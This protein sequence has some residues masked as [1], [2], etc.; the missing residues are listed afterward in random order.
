[1]DLTTPTFGL[2]KQMVYVTGLPRAGS[3]LLCQLL[4]VHSQIYSIV[5]SSPLA[6]L[7]EQLRHG[8]SD[9]PFQLAQLDVDFDLAYGRIVNAF[10]GFINGWVQETDLPV[11][12]DKNRSWLGMVQTVQQLDP[13]F[14]MLVCV[15]DPIQILG[16]IEAQHQKTLLLDFPDHMAPNSAWFRGDALFSN[17]GV[18]GGPLR[19]IENF[20]DI[21]DSCGIKERV[22][23][24][25]FERL[26][27][28]PVEEMSRIFKWLGMPDCYIDPCNLPVKPHESDSYYRYKYRHETRSKIILPSHHRISPRI[29]R[30]VF[31][32]YRWFYD[33]LYPEAYP[34]LRNGNGVGAGYGM[35]TPAGEPSP[36]VATP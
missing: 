5:H 14:R 3:T 24:V 31:Y 16:S 9:S 29:Q 7:L 18:V 32:K 20:Q 34:D 8:I 10:R 4:G 6:N 30:E 12:V 15:R 13:G 35:G 25:V 27:S 23:F 11:V 1:M 33:S 19:A 28:N 2:A 21:T 22:F 36:P 26:V 17:S